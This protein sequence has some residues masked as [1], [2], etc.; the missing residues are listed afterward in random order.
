L[1]L[2]RAIAIIFGVG[3]VEAFR[4]AALNV[5]EE[6]IRK[7]STEDL[8]LLSTWLGSVFATAEHE[9]RRRDA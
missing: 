1:H 5:V 6:Q 7:A 4:M 2:P 3:T 8:K 9:R